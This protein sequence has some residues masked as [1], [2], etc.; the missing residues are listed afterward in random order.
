MS[1]PLPQPNAVTQH[2]WSGC[3]DGHFEFQSC[4]KCG[5]HQFPPRLTCT[6]CHNAELDWRRST[7]RGTVY[8]F[9]VA[10]RAPLDSFKADVPYVIAIVA[11][12]EGVR[13]MMNIRGADPASISIGMPVEIVFEPTDGGDYPL[14]QAIRRG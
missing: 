12:E 11:L 13:A 2:F 8:S 4:A 10:H 7:G 14:P 3:R 1:K 5:H 9:T 6:A